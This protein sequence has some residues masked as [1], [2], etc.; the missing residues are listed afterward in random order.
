MAGCRG[1]GGGSRQRPARL[2]VPAEHAELAGAVLY[3]VVAADGRAVK[4]YSSLIAAS[5][6]AQRVGGSLRVAGRADRS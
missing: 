6:H 2:P 1:C 4:R 3:E 5:G